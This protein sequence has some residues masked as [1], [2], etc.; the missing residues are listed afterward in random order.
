MSELHLRVLEL[1]AQVLKR[2]DMSQ[3]SL[4]D[5]RY[6]QRVIESMQKDKRDQWILFMDAYN[7]VASLLPE[8]ANNQTKSF[9]EQVWTRFQILKETK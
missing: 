3:E 2:G 5:I 4:D 9:C 6:V 1:I 7:E 8:F